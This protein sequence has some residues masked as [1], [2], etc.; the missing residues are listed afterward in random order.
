MLCD[1]E[2]HTYLSAIGQQTTALTF[3]SN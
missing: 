2:I 1:L 3:P